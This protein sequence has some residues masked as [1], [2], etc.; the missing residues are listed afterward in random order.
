MRIDIKKFELAQ[1]KSEKTLVALGIPRE[2]IRNVREGKSL[3]PETVGRIAKALSC[4]PE[5]IIME[6]Y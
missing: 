5:D 2:T 3:R 1:A 4:K 6:D